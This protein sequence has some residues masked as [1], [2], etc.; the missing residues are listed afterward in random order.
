MSAPLHRYV[1]RAPLRLRSALHIGSGERG[2]VV[3]SPVLKDFLHQPFIPGSSLKGAMRSHLERLLPAL[4]LS[5][6]RLFDPTASCPGADPNGQA[7]KDLQ[8]RLEPLRQDAAARHDLI[9][10]SVCPMCQAFGS[11]FNK[12]RVL[13]ADAPLRNPGLPLVETRDGVG[14]DRD[15]HR[16]VDGIKYDYE[17]VSSYAVFDVEITLEEPDP[18]TLGI[19]AL[20]F[21]E[22][23]R[24]H[25]ALGGLTSRGLG[26]VFID[27][28]EIEV[29][30]LNLADPNLRRE[31]LKTGRAPL[32]PNPIGFLVQHAEALA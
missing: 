25:I 28:G 31:Y 5:T 6:C 21:L 11:S 2:D 12:A 19:A 20:G 26:K 14:I 7:A 32:I 1:F 8:R 23:A 18:P 17:V 3:D 13:F 16:A 9:R 4:G 15:S 24:G 22:L 27:E 30:G 29:R 10:Q